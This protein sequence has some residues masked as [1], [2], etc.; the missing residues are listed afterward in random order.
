[1]IK[2]QWKYFY[3]TSYWHRTFPSE[4]TGDQRIK[5]TYK[6]TQ[7]LPKD[8]KCDK[9]QYMI[10]ALKDWTCATSSPP[11]AIRDPESS[12]IP[13]MM[14]QPPLTALLIQKYSNFDHPSLSSVYFRRSTAL[15]ANSD[16]VKKFVVM[17]WV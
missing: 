17:W 14:P 1:M 4:L 11:L 7:Y 3:E 9:P 13:F 15:D 12:P 10:S 2:M 16:A 6:N 5:I 8:S